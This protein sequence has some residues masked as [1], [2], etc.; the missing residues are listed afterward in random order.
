MKIHISI[1]SLGKTLLANSLV[2][3]TCRLHRGS[4]LWFMSLRVDP[5]QKAAA[6][7]FEAC[8]MVDFRT[9][10]FRDQTD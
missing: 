7:G 10:C 1:V 5:L 3:P 2:G 9:G 8:V 6:L 4:F